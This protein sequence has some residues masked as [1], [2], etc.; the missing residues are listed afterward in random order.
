MSTIRGWWHENR[1]Q[2]QR[3]FNFMLG[4]YGEAPLTCEGWINKKI[5][6]QHLYSPAIWSIFQLAD[7]LG[8][9]EKIRWPNPDEERINVPSDPH[10]YW[11]YRMHLNLETLLKENEFN[12]ELKKYVIESG[13]GIE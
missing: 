3:F 8:M 5:I 6:L 2:T 4:Q 11:H 10:H 7:L 1:E 9:D 12:V 13:R